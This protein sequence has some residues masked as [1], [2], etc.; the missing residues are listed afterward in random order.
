MTTTEIDRLRVTMSNELIH[1]TII[2]DA[3]KMSLNDQKVILSIVSQIR[4]DDEQFES[5]WLTLRDL[6]EITGIAPRRLREDIGK[7]CNRLLKKIITF[8]NP[9]KPGSFEK[10]TWFSMAKYDADESKVGFKVSEMLRPYLLG[11]ESKFTTYHLEQIVRMQSTYSIRMYELLRCFIDERGRYGK[12]YR[13]EIKEIREKLGVPEGKYKAFDNFRR[14]VIEKTQ[15]ELNEK[16]DINFDFNLIR[17]GRN[18]IAIEIRPE[19]VEQIKVT[20]DQPQE[21]LPEV[22]AAVFDT[23][24]TI[25]G[26]N[27]GNRSLLKETFGMPLII[28]AMRETIA[29]KALDEIETTPKKYFGGIL[30]K[31]QQISDSKSTEEKLTGTEWAEGLD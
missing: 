4:K 1:R 29:A 28:Q 5:Y 19:K 20:S 12:P 15:K 30:R 22:D 11:L 3:V 6:S 24:D 7:I 26:E 13:L 9:D 14:S 16:S 21:M 17:K 2:E 23:V 25:L 31:M 8:V 10:M 18:V 27:A